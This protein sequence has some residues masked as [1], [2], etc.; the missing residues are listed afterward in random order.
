MHMKFD[1][2]NRLVNFA[3]KT[4]VFTR[5]LP[6]EYAA[7]RLK[8]QLTR[9]TMS[10]ALNYG[11]AQAAESRRDFKHKI[12]IVLKEL[13]E[14]RVGMKILSRLEYGNTTSRTVLQRECE[15]LIA[16]FSTI[17]KRTTLDH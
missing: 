3:T 14:S 2:E 8:E 13:K 7:E 12:S 10:S 16:I 11:E 15:E 5:S 17:V 4:I 9:S 1:L 6:K